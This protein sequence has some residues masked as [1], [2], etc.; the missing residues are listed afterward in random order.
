MDTQ[1]TL[2]FTATTLAALATGFLFFGLRTRATATKTDGR[3]H[4]AVASNL[5][6]FRSGSYTFACGRNMLRGSLTV[7]G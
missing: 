2:V 6:V 4:K 3:H 7:D 1:H 5:P